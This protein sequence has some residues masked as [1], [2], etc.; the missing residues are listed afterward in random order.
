MGKILMNQMVFFAYHGVMPEENRLGQKFIIDAELEVDLESSGRTD[1]VNDTVSY[2]DVFYT[3]EKIVTKEQ[4][5]L[6]EK[7]AYEIAVQILNNYMKIEAVT[8][9]VLKPEAPVAGNFRNFGVEIC[10]RR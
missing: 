6:I 2:A 1:D 3:I 8:V 10:K 9:R 4:F 5:K 7:L